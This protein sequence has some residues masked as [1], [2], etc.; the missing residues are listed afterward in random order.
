MTYYFY[1]CDICN[2]L[3]PC[4]FDGDCREDAARFF[5]DLLDD[6]YGSENWTAVSMDE[7]DDYP[8]PLALTV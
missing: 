4:Q 7:A 6:E 2:A 3:H 8:N 5:G 1:E